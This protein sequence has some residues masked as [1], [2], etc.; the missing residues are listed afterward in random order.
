M[1]S[2]PS[3]STRPAMQNEQTPA[4]S[5]D[6]VKQFTV[7]FDGDLTKFRGNPFHVDTPFGR[8]VAHG[9]GNIFEREDEA[10]EIMTALENALRRLMSVMPPNGRTSEQMNA[11]VEAQRALAKTETY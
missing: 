11:M 3:I 4:A 1:T 2:A 7:I 8:P 5:G 10:V 9:L 6:R